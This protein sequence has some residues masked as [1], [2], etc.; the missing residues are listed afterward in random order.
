[1]KKK[2]RKRF[3]SFDRSTQKRTHTPSYVPIIQYTSTIECTQR[4]H[5]II[6]VIHM[7]KVR[8][9]AKKKNTQLS[10]KRCVYLELRAKIADDDYVRR[11]RRRIQ[12]IHCVV[13]DVLENR[14]EQSLT[15]SHSGP[16]QIEI[17]SIYIYVVWRRMLQ[18]TKRLLYSNSLKTLG[19]KQGILYFQHSPF[20]YGPTQRYFRCRRMKLYG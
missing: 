1:M 11:R 9:T 2:K 4:T 17:Q 14:P 16:Y 6:Y 13:C 18:Q 20:G 8:G 12:N 15:P 10:A 7:I 5:N 19:C 3:H